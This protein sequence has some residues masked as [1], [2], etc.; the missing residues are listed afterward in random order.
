MPDINSKLLEIVQFQ[1]HQNS[2]ASK[3]FFD[4][5]HE[6][7]QEAII[8]NF[9]ICFC[10]CSVVLEDFLSVVKSESTIL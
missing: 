3:M 2:F 5:F 10:M 6:F 1:I 8:L 7:M 4:S 9:H